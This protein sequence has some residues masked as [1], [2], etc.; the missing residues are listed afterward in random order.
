MSGHAIEFAF[1]GFYQ[2]YP[3]DSKHVPGR[4]GPLRGGPEELSVRLLLVLEG[5]NSLQSVLVRLLQRGDIRVEALCALRHAVYI[6]AH[7]SHRGRL[8]YIDSPVLVCLRVCAIIEEREIKIK[9][10]VKY[11]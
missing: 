8:A 2:I 1:L 10:S 11:V 5:V 3:R 9:S 6:W 4:N 7:G